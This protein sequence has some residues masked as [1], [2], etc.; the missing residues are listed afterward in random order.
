M[1]TSLPNLSA[2]ARFDSSQS[3]SHISP[4]GAPPSPVPHASTAPNDNLSDIDANKSGGFWQSA[5]SETRHFAGG[6]IPHPTESTK[7]FTILR[8][9]PALVFYRGPT[10]SVAITIFSAP[11]HPLPAD[12]TIWLQQRGFSGDSGMKIKALVGATSTWLDVTPSARVEAQGLAPNSERS[13]QRDIGKAAKRSVKEKGDAKAHVPRETHVVRIP[14]A[15]ADGYFRLVLCTGGSAADIDG[16]S[17]RRKVLCPSPIFRIASTSTDS[18]VMRGASLSTMPI[19]MGVKVASVMASNTVNR[20]LAPVTAV[21]QAGAS[22]L[23]PVLLAKDAGQFLFGGSGSKSKVGAGGEQYS[24]RDPGYITPQTEGVLYGQGPEVVG[25]DEG[26]ERPFPVKFQ[27]RVVP[28]TGRSRGELGVPTA[29]LADIP[30]E[31]KYSLRG[32]YF[33]WARIL[34]GKGLDTTSQEW[35]EALISAGPS[36][37]PRPSVVAETM[38][39]VH[40]IHNFAGA[41][42]FNAK[43]K[44][45]VMGYLRP[46]QQ[47]TAPLQD[48]LRAISW[49]VQLTGAS[50]SRENWGPDMTV[51]RLKSIKSSRSLSEKYAD[52]RSK[53]QKQ[54]ER[55]PV[56]LAGIRAGDGEHRDKIHGNGGYWVAR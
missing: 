29:N 7:H 32:V 28:G 34:P 37:Y 13:W 35:H 23:Q 9:S 44:V 20:Y 54:V 14:E 56:H 39:T 27:G 11:K 19:E 45:I 51:D 2:A 10:T 33:G 36:P 42:F 55:V 47:P 41:N 21:A 50:L 16:G 1:M 4:G 53:V 18:S 46:M 3:P 30:E 5:L 52:T 48:R 40:L 25:S 12:R 49:D 31:V 17:S 6:L 38:M 24:E 8:H 15:S 43:M 22:K 26:P